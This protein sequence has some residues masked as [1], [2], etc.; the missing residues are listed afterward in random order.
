MTPGSSKVGKY[1][2]ENFPIPFALLRSMHEKLYS[3][4]LVLRDTSVGKQ[5]PYDTYVYNSQ[6]PQVRS[7]GHCVDFQ[8]CFWTVTK[9]LE[10]QSLICCR[11]GSHSSNR[12]R[13]SATR[14]MRRPILRALTTPIS[15]TI[16]MIVSVYLDNQVRTLNTK[17]RAA[18]A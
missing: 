5:D 17:T 13:I 1:A 6:R 16:N 10:T 7:P 9:Q 18:P 11:N 15:I 12:V 4:A 2:C 14:N 8:Y 3:I